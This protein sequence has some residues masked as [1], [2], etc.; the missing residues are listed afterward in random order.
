M[1]I[2]YPRCDTIIRNPKALKSAGPSESRC[3]KAWGFGEGPVASEGS[4]ECANWL[5]K[6]GFSLLYD[7]VYSSSL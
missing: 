3:S 7:L 2:S 5:G 6:S 1:A 4:F